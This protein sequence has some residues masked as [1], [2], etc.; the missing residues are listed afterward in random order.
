MLS[1]CQ[2]CFIS[3]YVSSLTVALLFCKTGTIPTN[4]LNG[5]PS[6]SVTAIVAS[7]DSNVL[8]GTVPS[9][10]SRI[11]KLNIN[12][13]GNE[14]EAIASNLC[15]AQSQWWGGDVTKY[16]NCSGLLC[17]AGTFNAVGRQYSD[18]GSCQKCPGSTL[19]YLGSIACPALEKLQAK[20]VLEALYNATNG[21]N[22]KNKDGWMGNSDFC[23]WHGLQCNAKGEVER[24]M[25][26]G[27]NLV[28]TV[29]T[30]IYTLPG[31][32]MLW[33][34][35]NAIE[36]SF[37]GIEKAGSLSS[38]QLDSIGL[39]TLAGIGNAPALVDVDVRFNHLAGTLPAS[40]IANLV[41]LETFFCGDNQFTGT[42]P[43]FANN[44]RLT[45]VRVGN[46]KFGGLLPSFS[47]QPYL[48]SLD[49]SDNML[50]GA[51]P[52]NL[53]AA[54]DASTPIYLDLS[55]NEFS[56]FLPSTLGKFT[57]VTIYAQDNRVEGISPTLCSENQ[58]NGGDVGTFGC[59]GI[60]CPP[61]SFSP[62]GRASKDGSSCLP[63][64]GVAYFGATTCPN[65]NFQTAVSTS[66]GPSIGRAI[67]TTVFCV[68]AG[69]A[70]TAGVAITV[71]ELF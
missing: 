16:A 62:A 38:L 71:A 21:N 66:S 17:P 36:F 48:K 30:D 22:W 5:V 6:Q 69:A 63:C 18:A 46:N 37:D 2:Q 10:L 29:P 61:Q 42:L 53:L 65:G 31:L 47:V 32:Q 34:Y 4:F 41:F 56:G 58:W 19:P 27:N 54:V 26:G 3:K 60:L 23:S 45:A 35:S 25:L 24:I 12:L 20:N 9:E 13:A 8:T 15:A 11:E 55:N 28:G 67:T 52:E 49:V 44:R 70:T 43:S 50:I 59:D 1:Y 39:K 64:N 57:D 7:L 68:L 14:I 51:I 40:E 33:L